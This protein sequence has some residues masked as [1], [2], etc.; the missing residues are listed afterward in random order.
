MIG[1]KGYDLSVGALHNPHN[2]VALVG[3]ALQKQGFVL[4]PT[5][6]DGNRLQILGA[7]REF[8]RRLSLAGDG[9]T[10]FFYYSGHGAAD[11]G[12]GVNYLIPIDARRPGTTTFWDSSI[13]LDEVLAILNQARGAAKLVVFDACRNELQLPERV[14]DKGF[15]PIPERLG[16]MSI[17]YATSHGSVA[18]DRGE[19]SGPYAAALAAQL[20]KPGLDHLNFFQNVKEAVIDATGGLQVPW[21][22]HGLHH[23]VMLTGP[24]SAKATEL[25]DAALPRPAMPDPFRNIT[26][27]SGVAES[28]EGCPTGPC[29]AM[30]VAPRGE[31]LMG[32]DPREAAAITRGRP[33]LER[34][35]KR[36]QPRVRVKIERPFAVS[37]SAIT[38]GQ[39]ATFVAATGYKVEHGCLY[40]LGDRTQL[41]PEHSWRDP[42]FSQ[43]DSHPVVCISWHDARAYASWLALV[44]K[45]RYRLLSEAEV[46]YVTRAA[47]R[48]TPQPLYSFGNEAIELCRHANIADQTAAASLKL[49]SRPDTYASCSDDFV[50]TAP[51][52]QLAPNAWGLK[53]VHGNAMTW[54]ADCWAE[55]HQGNPRDG[56]PR[57]GSG[58][59]VDC[60]R[61]VIRGA[62]WFS[63]PL[64]AR[65]ASRGRWPKADRYFM[66][67]LRVAREIEE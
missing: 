43:D 37:R 7:V 6:L 13:K 26:P 52:G 59:E 47:T 40:D 57:T 56:R 12:T 4:L 39:F 8:A 63:A 53:D 1:N 62:S 20:Q 51:V 23:R 42:G 46:E 36:E 10:G 17:V 38:R 29:P 48:A 65:S 67:G 14:I 24:S 31:F 5:V 2:D 30:V 11:K 54:T 66:I 61:S 58:P 22:S 33:D 45:R 3:A 41:A 50:Y 64:F 18:S 35:A 16:G 15:V 60:E 34:H 27:G 21:E 55:S 49:E 28:D 25:A 19:S 44:T 32:T 9:A